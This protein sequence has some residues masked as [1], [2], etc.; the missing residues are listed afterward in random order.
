MELFTALLHVDLFLFQFLLLMQNLLL[1][2]KKKKK[3]RLD[4]STSVQNDVLTAYYC[5]LKKKMFPLKSA[6]GVCP[7]G[8][9]ILNQ[10]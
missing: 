5:E 3:Y 7:H 2:K 9:I 10:F 4:F 8:L 1:Q 6:F